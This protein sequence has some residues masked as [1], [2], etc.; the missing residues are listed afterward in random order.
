MVD[1]DHADEVAERLGPW[2]APRQSYEDVEPP[3]DEEELQRGY[4][5]TAT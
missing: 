5:E 3:Y 4:V 1:P 2:W